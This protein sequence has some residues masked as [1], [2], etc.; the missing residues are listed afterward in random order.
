M[1]F[2]LA[3]AC[4]GT[5]DYFN[6]Q[7]PYDSGFWSLH[8]ADIIDAW[9]ITKLFKWTFIVMA[10]VGREGLKWSILLVY[11]VLNY[12]I[13]ETIYHKILKKGK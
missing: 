7:V 4:D 12:V 2:A 1:F 9:H 11:A 13:H 6:F 5:M 8:T 3:V 10:I